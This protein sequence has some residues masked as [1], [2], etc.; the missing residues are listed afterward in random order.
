M[1]NKGK[2]INPLPRDSETSLSSS[3]T[4]SHYVAKTLKTDLG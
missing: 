3:D 2:E 1:R 4:P